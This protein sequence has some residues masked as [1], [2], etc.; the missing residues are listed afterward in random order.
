[1]KKLRVCNLFAGIGGNRKNWDECG[2]DLEI[3]AVENNLEIVEIYS[4]FFPNDTVV[5]KDAHE[6]LLNH[7]KEF[8][9]IFSSPPCPTHS[10]LNRS[11]GVGLTEKK[12]P[13]MSLYQEIIFLQNWFKGK[14]CVE[15]VI[16][17]Y[18]PL[19]KPQ[20]LENHFW[21]TNFWI[22]PIDTKENRGHCLQVE[23][24]QERKGFDLSKYSG[25][26]K[27]KLLRNCVEP[28]TG[29]HILQCALGTNKQKQ[30]F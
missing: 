4:D 2:V 28:E 22:Q 3:V 19:I 25:I 26:D 9:F 14:Y 15:N 6:Y 29:K 12:Y 30:L 21:W 27:R 17:Y 8:D 7:Y 5:I 20:V 18:E 11:N 1:M 23:G 24:L 16:S 10:R 13:E